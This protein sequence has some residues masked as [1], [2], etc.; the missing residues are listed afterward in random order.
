MRLSLESSLLTFG[1]DLDKE[2]DWGFFFFTCFWH[3]CK[4]LRTGIYEKVQLDV[5]K[6]ECWAS[7]EVS[8]PLGAILVELRFQ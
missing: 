4:F 1:E 5:D 6:V 2:A 8:T 7:A 3:F